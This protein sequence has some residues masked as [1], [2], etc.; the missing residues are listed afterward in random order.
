VTTDF[1]S[2]S[3][4]APDAPQSMPATTLRGTGDTAVLLLHG[5]GGGRSLWSNAASSTARLL[6]DVGYCTVAIDLPGYGDSAAMGPPDMDAFVQAVL[7]VI[8]STGAPCTVLLGHSMG[9][10]IAQEVVARAPDKVQGLILACTSASFGKNDGEWQAKFLA[11]RLAPLDAGEGMWGMAK[12]LV[13]SMLAPNA[14]PAALQ[15]AVDVMSRVP[16]ATYRAALKTISS[17]DRR[18][19]LGSIGVPTLVLAGEDDKTAPP[20]VMRRMAERI[21]LAEFVCLPFAGHIANVEAPT[22]FNEAVLM[23]LVRRF[24]LV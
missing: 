16:E 1:S 9:G 5:I 14:H 18:A 20:D 23:F 19:A 12:R 15:V 2:I 11:E 24:P 7:D 17:F 13:P 6:A 22:A 4:A 3:P 8:A 21:P 10:M